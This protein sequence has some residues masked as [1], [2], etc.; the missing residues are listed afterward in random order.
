M[1][2]PAQTTPTLD[3][4]GGEQRKRWR[5]LGLLASAELLAMSLWFSGSAVVPALRLEWSLS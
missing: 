5:T 1:S 3:T 2:A 4:L